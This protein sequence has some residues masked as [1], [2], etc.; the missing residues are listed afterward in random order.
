MVRVRE[1]SLS[2][3]FAIMM[4]SLK[5]LVLCPLDA[6]TT[7]LPRVKQHLLDLICQ[8]AYTEGDFTLASGQKSTYYINCKPVTLDPAGAVAIGRLFL[9]MLPSTTQAV[10]GLTLGADPV[11][12]AVSVAGAYAGESIPALIIRKQA[13]GHGTQAYIEGPVLSSG[14]EVVVVEDVVTTGQSALTAVHRLQNAGYKVDRVIALVD[15]LQGG[16][17][18]YRQAG[19]SFQALFTIAEVQQRWAELAS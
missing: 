9:P 19:L 16:A 13:K 4:E 14:S 3:I 12:T 5:S 7:D 10:A 2:K 17:E 8:F 6:S 15:R 1:S 18:L 11:V